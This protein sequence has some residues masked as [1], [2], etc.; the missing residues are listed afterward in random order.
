MFNYRTL[1]ILK[2]E[3]REKLLSKTFIILTLAI[4]ALMFVFIGAQTLLM[5]YEGD[6]NTTLE[7]ITE[8]N[9]LT[10]SFQKELAEL[11]FIKTGYYSFKYLTMPR[12]ELS[13]YLDERKPDLLNETLSGIIFIPY[14]ALENKEIEYYSKVPKNLTVTQKLSQY[15]NKVL[16]SNYFSGKELSQDDLSFA[17]KGVDYKGFKISKDQEIEEE[18]F[19]NL[20][21]SYL[22]T[23]LL[24]FSLVMIGQMTMQSVMEEKNSKVVEVLL[25]SVSAKELMTGKIFGASIPGVLQMA[26]WLLPIVFV[27]FTSWFTLP[28]DI[29]FNISAGQLLYLLLNFFIGL[30]TFL[31]LFVMV[32]SIFET[33]QEAQSGM[34]PILMLIIFPF[35]IAMS[36]AKNP[37]NPIAQIASMFPFAS[38]IVMPAR[39][40]LTD[41]PVWQFVL[42]IIISIATIIAIFPLA[43]KI[44][45]VGILRT[46]KKPSWGEVIKWLK[47][48]Y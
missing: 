2:R 21:L 39:M 15:I 8:S 24:Y 48:K 11:P 47:Y 35:F 25:S 33:A 12:D 13:S 28:S 19:G 9:E 1:G 46:G 41:V 16:V 37:G 17:R 3:L 44:F 20:V 45:R 40:T 42:S 5:S 43:G 14:S 32:G 18:G 10:N 23:F 30:V 36:M 38:I 26:V 6:E 7:L 34:W 4:P 27:A 22:F 31:G 29:S